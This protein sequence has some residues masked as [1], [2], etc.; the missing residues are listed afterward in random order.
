IGRDAELPLDFIER[1]NPFEYSE[2]NP[3]WLPDGRLSFMT[4]HLDTNRG[5][6]ENDID[7]VDL[8]NRTLRNITENFA[9]R[10]NHPQWSVDGRW[11]AFEVGIANVRDIYVMDATTQETY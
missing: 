2:N 11:L 4:F 9:M 6:S 1:S 5:I 10:V 7:V 8:V 3:V